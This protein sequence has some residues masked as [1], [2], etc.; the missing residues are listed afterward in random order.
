MEPINVNDYERLVRERLS[1]GAWAYYSSGTDDEMTLREESAAFE[2]V[3]LLPRTP[4]G[5]SRADLRATDLGRVD[6]DLLW[7]W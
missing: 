4:R 6:D 5:V 7:K 2:R 1:P 3:R